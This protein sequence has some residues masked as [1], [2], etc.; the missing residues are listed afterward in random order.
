MRLSQEELSDE[1]DSTDVVLKARNTGSWQFG[2]GIV[3]FIH[4]QGHLSL[5][6][7]KRIEMVL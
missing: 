6:D 4:K 5:R 3:S 7:A 1:F 2:F